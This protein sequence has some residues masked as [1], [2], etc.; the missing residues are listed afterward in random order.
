MKKWYQS[1]T[2]WA[3]IGAVFTAVGLAFQGETFDFTPL[4]PAGLALLNIVLRL[5]TKS[6][7]S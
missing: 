2:M 7:I 6:P 3:N 4:F 1:K 5:V